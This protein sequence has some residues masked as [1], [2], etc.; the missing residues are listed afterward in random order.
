M[1]NPDADVTGVYVIIAYDEAA[2]FS[3]SAA[4]VDDM[5]SDSVANTLLDATVYVILMLNCES[6]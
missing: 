6:R 5:K 2:L 4:S 1:N 3:E